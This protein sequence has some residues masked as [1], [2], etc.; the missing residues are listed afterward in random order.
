MHDS[1][2]NLIRWH[3]EWYTIYAWINLIE[4]NRVCISCGSR[5]NFDCLCMNE[6]RHTRTYIKLSCLRA[7]SIFIDK[8]FAH[9][10]SV[11]CVWCVAF[12]I[13]ALNDVSIKHSRVLLS[14]DMH[15]CEVCVRV[16]LCAKKS[17]P[18]HSRNRKAT[19]TTTSQARPR[20]M[21]SCYTLSYECIFLTSAQ[22]KP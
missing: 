7:R 11:V 6:C 19:A 4:K 1:R 16:C 15:V 8:E 2:C 14:E 21:H 3:D 9:C 13:D 20:N 18:P 17:S 22:H 10:V 5:I 12:Y